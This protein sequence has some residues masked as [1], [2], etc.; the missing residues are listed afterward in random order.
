MKP[1]WTSEHTLYVRKAILDWFADMALK[2]GDNPHHVF[3][4]VQATHDYLSSDP[5]FWRA[6]D[7]ALMPSFFISMMQDVARFNVDLL[8]MDVPE[9]P[10]NL[11]GGRKLHAQ[12]HLQ[13]ELNEF[14]NSDN[15]EES[16]DALIDL[17]YVAMGRLLEMGVWPIPVFMEVHQANMKK[18]QGMVEGREN[19]GGL[20]ATKPAGWTPPDIAKYLQPIENLTTTTPEDEVP[21]GLS[22]VL[23]EL[24]RLREA[25]GGDY[26]RTG[27]ELHDY[28]PFGH[29]SYGQMVY[30]KAMRVRALIGLIQSGDKPN[31]EGLRDSLLD[32]L[33]YTTFYVEAMDEGR[34]T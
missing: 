12:D 32:L 10:R 14:K 34:V 11:I 31:F 23:V 6:I 17:I 22:P 28:F 27:V 3:G 30:L 29:E 24:A 8:E 7:S 1:N 25:K 33:N 19:S 4:D 5:S 16:V 26:N 15:L 21:P 9:Q 13:E 2:N 20:D 18:R